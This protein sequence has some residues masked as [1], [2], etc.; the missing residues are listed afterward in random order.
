MQV[1]ERPRTGPEPFAYISREF[2]ERARTE[3]DTIQNLNFFQSFACSDGLENSI[4]SR[5]LDFDTTMTEPFNPLD[6]LIFGG[7]KTV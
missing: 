2:V 4:C 7:F 3:P 5:N 1:F 6:P